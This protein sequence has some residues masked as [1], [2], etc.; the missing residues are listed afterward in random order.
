MHYKLAKAA[1]ERMEREMIDE[2]T[3]DSRNLALISRPDQQGAGRLLLFGFARYED[4]TKYNGKTTY[5]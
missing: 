1:T 3:C 4:N 5:G 2:K